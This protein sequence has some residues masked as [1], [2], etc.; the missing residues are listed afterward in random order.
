MCLCW[1]CLNVTVCAAWSNRGKHCMY[2]C[3]HTHTSS[4]SLSSFPPPYQ[5]CSLSVIG[6]T[7]PFILCLSLISPLASQ[8][9]YIPSIYLLIHLLCQVELQHFHSYLYFV[10]SST[11]VRVNTYVLY[12]YITLKRPLRRGEQSYLRGEAGLPRVHLRHWLPFQIYE[13][14]TGVCT[15]F[16]RKVCC[17]DISLVC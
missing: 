16:M 14:W 11:E 10:S 2:V 8:L 9:I 13:I 15:E 3:A 17:T 6:V 4:C 1:E 7:L 12:H 5:S